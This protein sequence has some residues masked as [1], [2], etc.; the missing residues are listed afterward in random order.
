M[1][2]SVPVAAAEHTTTLILCTAELHFA[3]KGKTHDMWRNHLNN[4][5]P[6]HIP[7][8]CHPGDAAAGL[9]AA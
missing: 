8:I 1:T 3:N 2:D 9:P 7:I 5:L 6:G 4:D